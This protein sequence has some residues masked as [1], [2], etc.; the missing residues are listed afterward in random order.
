MNKKIVFLDI[1]GTLVEAGSNEPPVS[2]IKAIEQARKNGHYVFLCT[3]RNYGMLKPLLQYGFDGFIGSSGGYICNGDHIIYDMPMTDEQKTKAFDVLLKNNIYRTIECC[4]VS[5]TD[6]SFKKF[7]EENSNSNGNSELLRWREQIESSLGIRPMKE[8]DGQPVYKIVIMMQNESQLEEPKK[9]LGD[10]FN[11][12]IQDTDQYGIINGEI[13]NKKF[14]K[15][16]AV[17]R[18]CEYLNIDISQSI[19]VGDSANDM[20]MLQIAGKSICMDNGSESIKMLADEI[21]P[22]VK[23]DGILWTMEKFVL[24]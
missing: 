11:F 12:C 13:V 2:A 8:Y 17:K 14:D 18:V 1:D 5:Y 9:V 21:C 20:E 3:G 23:N 7:L 10:D 19:A 22:S 16:R 4:D 6:E 15:G 24:I